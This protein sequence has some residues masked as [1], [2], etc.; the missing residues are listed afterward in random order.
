MRQER[1]IPSRAEV[2]PVYGGR[3]RRSIGILRATLGLR[4]S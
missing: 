2:H 1:Q 3:V 4:G